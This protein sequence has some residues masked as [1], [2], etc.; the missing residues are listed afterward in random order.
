MDMKE[1]D[2]KMYAKLK[3]HQLLL[4]IVAVVLLLIVLLPRIQ[5]LTI[6]GIVEYTPTSPLVA[7]AVFMFIYAVK[8][9]VMVVPISVLYVASG[10]VFPFYQAILITGVG[11]SVAMTIGYLNGRHLGYLKVQKFICKYPKV[12]VLLDDKRGNILY[13]CF[14]SR[15]IPFPFDLV[16][17]F[18]GAVSLPFG[19]YVLMSLLGIAPK[20]IPLILTASHVTDMQSPQ[21]ITSLV[22]SLGIVFGI[23]ILQ[24][25]LKMKARS[26]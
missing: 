14:L 17:M 9:V 15:L 2:A 13:L 8:A 11:V 6:D 22:I 5:Y 23:V 21:F 12:G 3:E 7:F 10:I 24:K 25:K 1:S 20:A 18:H 19:K 16:S 4:R 26:L